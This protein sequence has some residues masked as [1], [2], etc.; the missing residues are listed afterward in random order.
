MKAV[1]VTRKSGGVDGGDEIR[2][3]VGECGGAACWVGQEARDDR[4]GAQPCGV[5]G[6]GVEKAKETVAE[7]RAVSGSRLG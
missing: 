3:G 7:G 6:G 4:Q 1:L 5:G 2:V